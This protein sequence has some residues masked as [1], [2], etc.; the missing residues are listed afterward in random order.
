LTTYFIGTGG[1]AYFQILGIHLL[2]AYS[3]AFNFVEVN[4]TFYE[5][6]SLKR[7]EVW[8]KMVPSNFQ[9][10]VRANRVIT[11]KHRFKPI[12]EVFEALEKNEEDLRG[13]KRVGAASSNFTENNN[14]YV[15]YQKP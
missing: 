4:A 6:P 10:A 5:I 3:K 15:L 2:I 14:Q 12:L 9:F 7:V 13:S 11:H 8:R 1:R